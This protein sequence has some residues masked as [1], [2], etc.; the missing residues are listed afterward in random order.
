[1]AQKNKPRTT[2]KSSYHGFEGVDL[3]KTHSGDESIALIDNFRI[4]DDGSLKKRYGFKKVYEYTDTSQKIKAP[5]STIENGTE[6][7]YFAQGKSIKK[8]N[9]STRSVTTI[10]D[11][12]TADYNI[13][14]FEY[15]GKLYVCD[16][17]KIFIIGSSS[18]SEETFYIP[19][20][21]KDWNSFAGTINEPQN[22][23]CQKV[24]ISYK[25]TSPA[26]SYLSL[27]KLQ[28]SSIDALYRNGTLVSSDQYS[29]NERYNSIAVTDFA[30]NDVFFAIVSF[31][32][33]TRYENQKSALFA[34]C[35]TSLF[36]E[37]NKNNLFFWGNDNTNQIFYT[38]AVN[39]E[40]ATETDKYATH[41]RF[42]VP[43]D[44][45]FTVASSKDRVKAFI[46]HYDRTLIMTDTSTWIT[47]LQ[48][49]ENKSLKLKNINSSI[50]CVVKN[51]CVRIEN[52]LFS[53]GKDAIYEW[54]S[55]TDELNE[56]NAHSI[57]DPIK[58]LLD[59]NFFVNCL[60]HLNYSKREIWFFNSNQGKTWIYNFE[61]KAWYAFSG[62]SPTTF[63]EGGNEV[64]FFA[65]TYLHA[66]DPTLIFDTYK[67]KA[68]AI[69]GKLK[70]G[71]L[72]FNDKGKKKLYFT[73]VS[74]EFS[75][76]SLSLKITLDGT[77][78]C[79]FNISPQKKHSVLQFR[80]KSG[81]FRSLA[82][83]LTATGAGQQIIH[84]IE[85]YA[86]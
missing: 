13:F 40:T 26:T 14:F 27:G 42:Y 52:T 28:V 84:G 49:I 71:E 15:L 4:T 16:S 5:Y 47:N 74:G 64:C 69:T 46:R 67:T 54:N 53:I 12:S 7:C 50:G 56:C 2:R 60:M 18:L 48:D 23:L 62:F 34:S 80:T 33:D 68:L 51:G 73:T 30:D 63:L 61:R 1:M 3:K 41:S 36:S 9:F 35:Y 65:D 10:G 75:V 58:D 85:F 11:V 72:E 31:S 79:Q 57:S 77:Y 21:G 86:D 66:F 32:P 59:N 25:L 19:L 37:L 83:E 44:S 38:N 24:A 76:K 70:S 17:S 29:I 82:F 45:Y 20:Y 8:Y 39:E 78:A 81:A 6:F 22:L 55:D 43:V